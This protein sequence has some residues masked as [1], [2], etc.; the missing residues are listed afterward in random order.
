MRPSW[1]PSLR[2]TAGL[3]WVHPRIAVLLFGFL[4]SSRLTKTGRCDTHDRDNMSKMRGLT[5]I[6]G[7]VQGTCSLISSEIGYRILGQSTGESTAAV[8]LL[9]FTHAARRS[10][11][12]IP[13]LLFSVRPLFF[14]SFGGVKLHHQTHV[15]IRFFFSY[16]LPFLTFVHLV[17]R[18]P[19][20]H[21]PPAP[22]RISFPR[23]SLV[24]ATHDLQPAFPSAVSS[25]AV[26]SGLA[27]FL[28]AV[29]VDPHYTD[30]PPSPTLAPPNYP[31]LHYEVQPQLRQLQPTRV[32]RDRPSWPCLLVAVV[33]HI[34]CG[35]RPEQLDR[36]DN[37]RTISAFP[38]PPTLAHHRDLYIGSAAGSLDA[39]RS[40]LVTDLVRPA[41]IQKTTH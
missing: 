12:S 19:I 31:S 35:T 29:A 27:W 36:H 25:S 8:S 24:A 39:A 11:P 40:F 37:T 4:P 6:K 21:P 38:R 15:R 28:T 10:S 34:G 18:P 41:S 7:W 17:C 26:T 16:F 13:R 5:P 30:H 23:S 20:Q 2:V 3:S 33:S 14:P 32:A 22:R 1:S 9:N